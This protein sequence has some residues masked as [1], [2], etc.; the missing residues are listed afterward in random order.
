M[1]NVSLIANFDID[2]DANVEL[3]IETAVDLAPKS[4][5]DSLYVQFV[6]KG[7]L[8]ILRTKGN[9]DKLAGGPHI[10]KNEQQSV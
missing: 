9:L 1:I 8:T 4:R 5:E 10:Q 7:N 2:D 3:Y 6:K